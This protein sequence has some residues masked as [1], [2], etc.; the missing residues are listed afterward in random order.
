[1]IVSTRGKIRPPFQGEDA[2]LT[3]QILRLV[4]IVGHDRLAHDA[5]GECARLRIRGRKVNAEHLGWPDCLVYNLL[6]VGGKHSSSF[7]E[8]RSKGPQW[9]TQPG[10]VA[11]IVVPHDTTFFSL[12][13]THALGYELISRSVR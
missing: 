7:L 12:S 10:G 11:P 4:P 8:Q 5:S 9:L 3:H 2:A 1:M 13:L 6:S